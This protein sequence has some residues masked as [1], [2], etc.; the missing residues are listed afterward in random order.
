MMSRDDF[1]KMNTNTLRMQIQHF[2]ASIDALDIKDELIRPY[3]AHL[4]A[5]RDI[6]CGVYCKG[7]VAAPEAAVYVQ[8]AG[9]LAEAPPSAPPTTGACKRKVCVR[10]RSDSTARDRR[11]TAM[12]CG[13]GPS[14]W[15]KSGGWRWP[16]GRAA[17]R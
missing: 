4:V 7:I 6:A 12:I 13:R 1:E 16:R 15:P 17:L 3:I 10:T 14:R 2:T 5:M 9:T 11:H 8:G